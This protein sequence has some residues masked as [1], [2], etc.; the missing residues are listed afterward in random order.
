[1]RPHGTI[2]LRDDHVDSL[3]GKLGTHSILAGSTF[4]VLFLF[5]SYSTINQRQYNHPTIHTQQPYVY[6]LHFSTLHYAATRCIFRRLPR[7]KSDHHSSITSHRSFC[8]PISL[9][10]SVRATR[11]WRHHYRCIHVELHRPTRKET[12]PISLLN[13]DQMGSKES[14][15]NRHTA[16]PT[17]DPGVL[18]ASLVLGRVAGPSWTTA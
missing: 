11:Q 18:G 14:F 10:C 12:R 1:M 6:L 16:H 5:T 2:S 9:I 8:M 3:F 15:P 7:Q 4:W 13:H 17:C